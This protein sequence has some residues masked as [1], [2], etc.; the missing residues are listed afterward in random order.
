MIKRNV[1]QRATACLAA[2][3]Y[4]NWISDTN[5]LKMLFWARMGKKLN[6]SNPRTFNEKLQW[7]KINNRKLEY[8]TMVDK[9]EVRQYVKDNIGEQYL[10][11]LLGGPWNNFDE[12]DFDALPDQFVL[13]CTHDS[14]GVIICKDKRNFNKGAARLRL[15]KSL[16]RNY[17]YSGREWPYKN[18]KPRIIA[19]K[20]MVDDS[21]KDLKDYK[22]MCFGGKVKCSFVCTN[23]D[24]N[25]LRVTFFDRQWQKMPFERHYPV[26]SK[27][28][29]K[30]IG[31]GEMICLAEKLAD[32]IPFVRVDFYNING[33]IYFGELTFYPGCGFEEFTPE[34]W[35]HK[36]GNW[37]TLP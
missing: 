10:I 17:Y 25:D 30:P 22:L 21:S 34:E 3:G 13:K 19:E 20:Y 28:I 7:L 8:T 35:D 27:N 4:L 18:V 32:N 5:Y 36:L 37:I 9:H 16:Q 31:Y 12:I 26:D 6:L 14:G 1:L 11:T 24:L 23:R 29:Q 2:K 15:N 33:K